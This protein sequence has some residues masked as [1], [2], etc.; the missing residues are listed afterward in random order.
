MT[1]PVVLAIAGVCLIAVG[2]VGGRIK[3]SFGQV[4]GTVSGLPRAISLVIGLLILGTAIWL[5]RLET[6]PPQEI[7]ESPSPSFSIDTIFPEPEDVL[8]PLDSPAVE[9][10]QVLSDDE[11]RQMLI[12]ASIAAYSGNCPCPYSRNRAGNRCG[13]N[14]AYSRP[15]GASPLCYPR[16]ITD[17]Q[18]RI[19]RERLGRRNN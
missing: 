10:P 11:I 2:I 7:V 3:L 14:S 9:Q 15:G 4:E 8:P 1:V 12:D 6:S 5:Y 13:G 19:A 18:V 16:D 17:E